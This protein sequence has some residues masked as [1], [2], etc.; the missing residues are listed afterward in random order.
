MSDLPVTA[1]GVIRGMLALGT[2][3][4]GVIGLAV[5][6]PRFFGAS[7]ACGGLWLAWDLL[8]DHV[9]GPLV[10]WTSRVWFEGTGAP[11]ACRD[12][13]ER[14]AGVPGEPED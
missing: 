2:A 11:P 3:V 10:G 5:D 9:F 8:R 4:F 1:G 14:A 13:P 6:D 7:A 12:A